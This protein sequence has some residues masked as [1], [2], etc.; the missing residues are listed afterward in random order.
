VNQFEARTGVLMALKRDDF[1]GVGKREKN[2][3]GVFSRE[4]TCKGER[5]SE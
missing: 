2:G 5:S 4:P 1:V 3:N